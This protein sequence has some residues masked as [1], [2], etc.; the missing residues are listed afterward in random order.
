MINR[1]AVA[2]TILAT[3][4]LSGCFSA[5]ALV[6]EE[7]DSSFYLLDTK[8]GSLC[9]G[10]TRMCIS[11]SIIASQNGSLAPVETA[12]KQ[13]ITG[14]NY[15]LSLMLILMKPNDNSY[16]ATKIGTTGNVYSLPKNDKTNLTWQTLNEIHNST[17][18]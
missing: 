9:N 15:P 4:L 18:N 14:P 8:S 16:R 3:S 2:L 7:K 17:Y 10:M 6:P 13:R 1:L 12:Y 11:L 5:S